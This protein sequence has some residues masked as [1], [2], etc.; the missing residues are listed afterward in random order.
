MANARGVGENSFLTQLESARSELRDKFS[1]ARR[2]LQAREQAM[3]LELKGI[4]DLYREQ[5]QRQTQ[6]KKELLATKEQLHYSLKGNENRDILQTMLAPLE[7][8]LRELEERG[9][10]FQRIELSWNRVEQLM[11]L[12]KEIG[13]IKLIYSNIDYTKKNFPVLVACKYRPDSNKP[14]QFKYPTFVAI[15]PKTKNIYIGDESNNR[16]QVFNQS[17]K[18]IFSFFE[19]MDSP[20]GICFNDDEVYVTQFASNSINIYTAN[21]DFKK[22]LGS[23][24]RNQLEFRGP[25]GACTSDY[26]NRVYICER[27]NNRIQVLNTDL[28]FNSFI[29][30][31]FQPKDVKVTRE[32]IF[33]LDRNSPCLHVYSYKHELL[34]GI[35]S[36]GRHGCQISNSAQFTVDRYSNILICDYSFCCVHIFSR[37]GELFHSFGK[38]GTGAGEFTDPTGVAIDSKGRIIVA[39]RN[40]EHCIQFF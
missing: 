37:D 16:V 8:K 2:L 1:L 22:S 21:G 25:F 14:E 5:V 38:R 7:T 28:T 24:G 3:L 33:V 11:H 39:S 6:Q 31:L 12:L 35:I 36:Y 10:L 26:N 19:K 30:G 34:K 18:F 17:C 40:P 15:S 27:S 20:A 13:T 9:E 32:E 29:T 4:E 23:E